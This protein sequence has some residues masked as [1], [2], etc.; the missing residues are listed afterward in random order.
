MLGGFKNQFFLTRAVLSSGGR[1]KADFLS[2]KNPIP[3]GLFA[4]RRIRNDQGWPPHQPHEGEW[5]WRDR[6]GNGAFDPDEYDRN[7]GRD[8]PWYH[9]C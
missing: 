9:A 1:Q 5:I 3:S 8:A 7:N 4:G 2:S 6:D